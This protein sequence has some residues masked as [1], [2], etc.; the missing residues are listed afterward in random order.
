MRLKYVLVTAAHNEEN[1]IEKTIAS[2][3]SQTVKPIKWLIVNDGS[4]DGTERIVRFYSRKTKWI[5]LSNMP[6]RNERNFAGKAIAFNHGWNK[7]NEL[8]YDLIGNIDA[9]I[10]FEPTYFEYLIDKF[11]KDFNLGVAGTHYLENGFHSFRDS[12]INVHHVNGQCQLFRRKCLED[13]GGYF[14][15]KAGGI[16]WIAVTTARMKGW[17]TYSFGDKVFEHHR[18]MGT[19]GGNVFSSRYNYGKK[20]YFLGNHPVWELLRCFYQIGKRPY[21]MG[22]LLLFTGYFSSWI[23]REKRSVP[24]VVVEFHRK[25][26]LQRI[27]NLFKNKF[28]VSR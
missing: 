9:D 26:Q 13:I 27:S 5:E 25:E 12:Y 28:K 10:T 19:A 20:D 18:G 14:S 1:L 3:L 11:E 22:G 16:D 23:R 17:K 6:E 15:N 2:V 21:I 24:D 7:V 8:R 4:T